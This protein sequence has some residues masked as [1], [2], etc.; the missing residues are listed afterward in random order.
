M[1]KEN[2]TL[3]PK[4]RPDIDG[5][6]AI[7][8][9]AV[10]FFHAFPGWMHGGFIGVDV[11][12]VLSGY[13][14]STIIFENLDQ[15]TFNFSEFY[16]R[17]IKRIFPGLIIV[18]I[19]CFIFAWFGLLSDE[20]KQLGKHIVA[21]SG[22]VSNLVLW[23]EA[24]YFD[25]S[26]DTKPLLHLWSLGIEEQ[27]YIVWPLLL[28]FAWKHK[29]NLLTI[30]I[31]VAITSFILN[32]KGVK[33]DMVATFYS[34][35][36][37]FWELL[38]GS[39]L[40]WVSLYKKN[41]F[42][43]V[44][45]KVDVWLSRIIYSEKQEADGKTLANVLASIG[46]L[47][48]AYGFWRINKNLPFPGTWALIPVIAT[49]LLLAAG[50]HT[51]I[52]RK[53]LSNKVAVW[54]GLI[55]FPLYLWHWPLLSFARI[56][57]NETPSYEFRVAVIL[58]SILLAWLTYRV[59]EVPIRA[60]R[61]KKKQAVV[62]FILMMFVVFIGSYTYIRDGFGFRFPKIV[63]EF[64][65]YKYGFDDF[66]VAYRLG[67][68][69]LRPDQDFSAYDTCN[70]AT[71]GG[72]KQELI[73]WG[74]SHAASLY[75]GY[76]DS[77]SNQFKIIQRTASS[78]PPIL[79]YD[80]D[81]NTCRKINDYVFEQIKREKPKKVVLAAA[82]P[83]YGDVSKRVEDTIS[84]L[85][86]IGV[87]D[88]DLIGPFPQWKDG[89]PRQLYLNYRSDSRREIPKRMSFGLN[90]N[91]I[92]MD[93]FLTSLAS[94]LKVNYISPYKILCDDHGCITRLGDTGDTLVTWDYGHLTPIGSQYLVSNFPKN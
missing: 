44:K 41:A 87:E 23:N 15:G 6:R 78:C 73:L 90:K 32:T 75:P 18:L 50:P 52:N 47:L 71:I 53:L 4:Y 68:C 48:L 85:R 63:Q 56:L 20:F 26:A 92:E 40:A 88:I 62:L 28:W 61:H 64:T 36:T 31:V 45:H 7:A 57:T 13:L 94:R 58:I 29:F 49:I 25:N 80:N 42:S 1:Y 76:K 3:H 74:D 91:F 34:P 5:L 77:F 51:W 82:W 81:S 67:S 93:I 17:R 11:F 27:F 10:V 22:F 72:K 35:Q 54:F 70:S 79:N 86:A 33:Q 2:K 38:S 83:N 59:V 30:T 9:I 19:A 37:R 12:F 8:V 65:Q 69:F 43:E 16:A 39:L 89:L 66:S 14:I 84:Q 60:S 46:L 55:S 24:G 21:G